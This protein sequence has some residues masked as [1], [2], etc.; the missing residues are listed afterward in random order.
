MKNKLGII[1]NLGKIIQ[2]V[3]DLQLSTVFIGI[4]ISLAMAYHDLTQLDQCTVSVVMEK[5]PF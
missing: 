4:S 2:S 3:K 5:V 1:E